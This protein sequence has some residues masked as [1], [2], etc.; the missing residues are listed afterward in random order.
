[1]SLPE[2]AGHTYTP[3]VAAICLW[4]E[5]LPAAKGLVGLHSSPL[6]ENAVPWHVGNSR[7]ALAGGGLVV[8]RRGRFGEPPLQH[9][10]AWDGG[11]EGSRTPDLLIANETL[12]QLSYDPNHLF[13]RLLGG[14]TGTRNLSLLPRAPHPNGHQYER[15]HSDRKRILLRR[16]GDKL[17]GFCSCSRTHV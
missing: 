15:S 17:V 9:T 2:G 14:E 11:A 12:Y 6:L 7:T 4:G 5:T 10:D 3:A 16:I 1:M 13:R 8:A